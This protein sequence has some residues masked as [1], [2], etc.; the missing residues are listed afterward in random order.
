VLCGGSQAYDAA[1]AQTKIEKEQHGEVEDEFLAV[2]EKFL[3]TGKVEVPRHAN[4]ASAE[5][6]GW[7]SKCGEKG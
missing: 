2:Y 3:K 1:Q 6:A 4:A 7:W 5:N